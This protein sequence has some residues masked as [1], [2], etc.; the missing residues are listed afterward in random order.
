MPDPVRAGVGRPPTTTP[1]LID[2]AFAGSDRRPLLARMGLQV[3]RS[4]LVHAE[5]HRRIPWPRFGTAVGDRVELED[6]V[7]LRFEVGVV[8]LLEGLDHL[9][10]H[11]LLAEQSAQALMADVVDHPLSHQ[12]LRQLRQAPGGERQA[13]ILRARQRDLLDLLTLGQRE[14]RRPTTRVLRCQRVEP[15]ALKLWIT[16]R[17][18]SSEVN[19]IL[20]IAGTSIAC[21]DHN[22]ICARRHLTTDPDPRRTIPRS[23]IPSAGARSRTCT[24]SAIHQSKQTPADQMVDAPPPTLPVTALAERFLVVLRGPR[25]EASSD[26]GVER[27]DDACVL[28]PRFQ[29]MIVS[30]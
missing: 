4:E 25:R 15:V 7:L 3:E 28:L 9:K 8:G 18:R 5:H 26:R 29:S 30:A 19:A 27:G 2:V 24:R 20:A 22:T 14:L 12:E 21:A 16:S 23:F 17:T 1:R 10:R 13:M 11:A 6:P